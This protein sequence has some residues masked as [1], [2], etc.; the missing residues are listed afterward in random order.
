MSKMS[1]YHH[2]VKCVKNMSKMCQRCKK[3]FKNVLKPGKQQTKVIVTD[4]LADLQ[5]D[6]E[7]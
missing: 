5:T 1:K 6:K 7:N 4:Y 3:S 2:Y